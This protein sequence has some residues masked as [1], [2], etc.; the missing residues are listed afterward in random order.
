M[1][2][3]Y[4]YRRYIRNPIPKKYDPQQR[5]SVILELLDEYGRLDTYQIQALLPRQAK[6][7][8]PR[9]WRPQKSKPTWVSKTDE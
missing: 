6:R 9:A 7:I 8:Y 3:K 2:K 4:F 5:D 1:A